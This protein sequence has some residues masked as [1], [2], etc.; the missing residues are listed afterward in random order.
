MLSISEFK[1]LFF[2]IRSY[3]KLDNYEVE[4]DSIK[5]IFLDFFCNKFKD[6]SSIF[7]KFDWCAI[8]KVFNYILNFKQFSSFK[9]P[10]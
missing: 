5:N 3:S 7:I 1:K 2:D 4:K 9:N 6:S 8:L 10:T